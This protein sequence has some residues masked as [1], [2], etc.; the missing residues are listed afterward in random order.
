[1]SELKIN[2]PNGSNAEDIDYVKTKK[3]IIAVKAV[4][5]A[6]HSVNKA[7][8]LVCASTAGDSWDEQ[9][10]HW[11]AQANKQSAFNLFI[12]PTW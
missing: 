1:M 5:Q 10:I 3:I 8:L 2:D 9:G 7:L 4:S 6:L 12:L 11:D